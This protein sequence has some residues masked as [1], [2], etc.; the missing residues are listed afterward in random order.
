MLHIV[1]LHSLTGEVQLPGLSERRV[2]NPDD[3]LDYLD[4]ANSLRRTGELPST[5][6]LSRSHIT[7]SPRRGEQPPPHR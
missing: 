4:E 6:W 1:R 5:Y 2:S 3:V 7:Y